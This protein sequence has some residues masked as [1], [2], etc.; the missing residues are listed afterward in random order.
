MEEEAEQQ[1]VLQQQLRHHR[2]LS[3][4]LL[5]CQLQTQFSSQALPPREFYHV[6]S[7]AT[8]AYE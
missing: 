8:N 5:S 6:H 2:Q 1:Q 7:C 3:Q 4:H